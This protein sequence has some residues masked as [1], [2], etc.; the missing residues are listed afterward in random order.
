MID[1]ARH[2]LTQLQR[3]DGHW[4]FELEADARSRPS[5]S[6]SSIISARSTGARATRSASICAPARPTMAAGRSIS[7]AISISAQRQSLFRAEAARRRSGGA[8]HGARARGDSGAW[9]CCPLQCVHPDHARA[10]R[11]GALARGAGHAGRDHAAA[12]LVPVPS[13][14]GVLL[15]AHCDRA[16][17]DPDGAASRAPGTRAASGSPSCSST[18]PEPSAHYITQPHRL[19]WGRFFLAVD[20]GLRLV[21][22]HFPKRRRARA[23]ERR[24][25]SSPSV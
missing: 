23:L 5:T 7:A 1:Q 24:S 17:P 11:P 3:A 15:V 18:P 21:E 8:A 13:R 20:R 10:V 4:V 12:A 14:Q 6:C 22:P 25:R 9:R 16:A 2:G 19:G